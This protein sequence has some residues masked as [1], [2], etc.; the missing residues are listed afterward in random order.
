MPAER[1]EDGRL[2][3]RVVT[4]EDFRFLSEEELT[5]TRREP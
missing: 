5:E 2:V 1:D 3:P 4:P